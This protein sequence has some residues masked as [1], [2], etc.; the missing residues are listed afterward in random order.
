MSIANK[1]TTSIALGVADMAIAT[2]IA[3]AMMAMPSPQPGAEREITDHVTLRY[4]RAFDAS[5]TA[6][7]GEPSVWLDFSFRF[8][9]NTEANVVTDWLIGVLGEKKGSVVLRF[10]NNE[11]DLETESLRRVVDDVLRLSV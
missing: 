6:A 1:R 8:D 11:V 9:R 3:S 4:L 5:K 10:D 2:E 7:P